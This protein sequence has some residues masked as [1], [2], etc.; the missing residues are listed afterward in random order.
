MQTT[1]PMSQTAR[2]AEIDL[3][4]MRR[5]VVDPPLQ[6]QVTPFNHLF[7]IKPP[8]RFLDNPREQNYQYASAKTEDYPLSEKKDKVVVILQNILRNLENDI[9]HD[10]LR[11]KVR[12]KLLRQF[13]GR[14]S[15]LNISKFNTLVIVNNFLK[16]NKNI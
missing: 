11:L 1:Q 10:R 3:I 8:E 2:G 12:F 13:K 5:N 4:N 14:Q 16:S 9:E 7:Y 15:F 6:F